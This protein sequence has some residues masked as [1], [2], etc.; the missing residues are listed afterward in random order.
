MITA[1]KEIKRKYRHARVRKKVFGSSDKPRLC[2]HR[3]LK[4]FYAQLIDDDQG[5][6]LF[7][8]STLSKSVREKIKS[9]GNKE[10]ASQ[11][12]ELF[13]I[14]AKEK[15]IQKVSFDRAGYIYHGRVKAFADGARKGGLEF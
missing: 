12:G 2:V 13:A 3:S 11:L 14:M 8:V 1:L 6:V 9:K 4:N 7:G 15:G 5:R 10:A